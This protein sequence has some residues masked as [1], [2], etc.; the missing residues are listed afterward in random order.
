[1]SGERLSKSDESRNPELPFGKTAGTQPTTLTLSAGRIPRL[2]FRFSAPAVVGMLAQAMYNVVDRVFVGH[3]LG[4]SGMAGIAVCLPYMLILLAFAMLIGFGAAAL[5]SIRLGQQRKDEA[6]RVLG[7]ALLL[8]ALASL[9][10]TVC[11]WLFVDPLLQFFGASPQILP[12]ARDYLQV[13]VLGTVFQMVGFGLNAPIRGEGNPRVAMLTILIGVVLNIVLA[14][15]FIFG[16]GWGMRGAAAATVLAQATSAGWVLAHF[17]SG[18]SLLRFRAR[19][20]RLSWPVCREILTVGS[21]PCAMQLAASLINSLLNWQLRAYGDDLAI[22]VM[23]IIYAVAMMIAMPIFGLNQG[24]Q[25]IIGYNYGARK[26]GR[27]K[28]TLQW[29]MLAATTVTV[30]GFTAV[31]LFPAAV[32]RLF[33]RHDPALVE[34]GVRALRLSLMLLPVVGFQV[35]SASYFQATGKPKQ[36]MLLGL[37]RQVLVLIPAVLVLPRLRGLDGVWLAMPTADLVSTVLAGVLLSRELRRLNAAQS[38]EP[39]NE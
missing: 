21:P 17:L 7:A 2:L 26:L 23:G 33:N 12:Y 16:W 37:S 9:A 38:A 31:M 22:S 19:H 29:A 4:T 20:L 14:P 34:L 32:I 1:M 27:V 3:A 28:E 35:I 18:S 10:L 24:A 13:I 8:L 6:E 11:G 30:L 5:I 39:M 25:P 36:A 15:V